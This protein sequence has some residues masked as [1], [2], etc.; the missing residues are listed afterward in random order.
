MA[1]KKRMSR[2]KRVMYTRIGILVALLLLII[3][4]GVLLFKLLFS[5]SKPKTDKPKKEDTAEVVP[6]VD[7]TAS[8]RVLAIG[9]VM[10]HEP[11]LRSP[12]YYNAE[13]NTYDFSEMFKY[14]KDDYQNADFSILTFEGALTGEPYTGY[15]MFRTPNSIMNSFQDAGIDLCMLANNHIYDGLADGV[16]MTMDYME[17]IN[18]DYMGIRKSTDIQPF[19]IQE[20]NGIKVGFI[21]YVYESADQEG[22]TKCI[23]GIGIADEMA[24]L[25]NTFNYNHLD[26]FYEEVTNA[27]T[28]M[29]NAGAE[30]VVAFMHWG[31]EYQLVENYLQDEIAQSLCNIGFNAIIGSHPHVIQPIDIL[32]SA[33]GSHQ[34]FCAYAIGNHLSNQRIEFMDGDSTG[35][36]EDGYMIYLT[37]DRDHDGN[38]QISNIEFL[39]T[40]VYMAPDLNNRQYFILPLDNYESLAEITGFQD[41]GTDPVDSIARTNNII[42]SG[43]ALTQQSLPIKV[44][45]NVHKNS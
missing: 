24:P 10:M 36:T 31:T 12:Y 18:L 45:G 37:I 35:E 15:P 29:K 9:D 8:A 6:D 27:Y 25:I 43:V 28:A 7:Y 13:S 40:W 34:T 42:G 17:Q 39:Y 19:K 20:I 33:D 41:L 16:M 3:A 23:N 30:I 2:R 11:F 38:V 5:S 4:G 32:T 22:Y 44:P 21:D 1:K 14:I 26:T